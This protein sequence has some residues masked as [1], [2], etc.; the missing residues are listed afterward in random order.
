MR[1]RSAAAQ[2]SNRLAKSIPPRQ[3]A[4]L[5]DIFHS[6]K[7]IREYVAG[8]THEQFLKD[9]KTQD[10]VLRRFL[11][12]GEA[13]RHLEEETCAQFPNIPFHKIAGMR[14]RVVHDYGNVDFEIIWETIQDH[15]P[16]LYEE[17]RRF[18]AQRGEP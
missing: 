1:I 6:V 7:V 5:L 16:F 2:S 12:A 17:L 11:V 3:V 8:L 10:A 15:L 4:Y 18:F 13:A 14:N 9:T